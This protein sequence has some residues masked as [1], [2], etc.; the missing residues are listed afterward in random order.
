MCCCYMLH[1]YV[2]DD[3]DG[4]SVYVFF[5]YIFISSSSRSHHITQQA[6]T[7]T[8]LHHDDHHQQRVLIVISVIRFIHVINVC[9]WLLLLLFVYVPHHESY[10]STNKHY[11]RARLLLLFFLHIVYI[12][13]CTLKYIALIFSLIHLILLVFFFL[14]ACWLKRLYEIFIDREEKKT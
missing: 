13:R 1:L 5:I 14:L 6:L 7:H 9:I 8:F 2:D 10:M 4:V 12:Y 11:L 3:D